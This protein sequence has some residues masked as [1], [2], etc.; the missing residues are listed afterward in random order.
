MPSAPKSRCSEDADGLLCL[1]KLSRT[2]A[3]RA[4]L[5]MCDEAVLVC[6][7]VASISHTS[8]SARGSV[9]EGM[10]PDSDGDL[11]TVWAVA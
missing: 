8:A 1:W 9:H 3:A 11:V 10:V 5:I 7:A 6:D 2:D 4:Q